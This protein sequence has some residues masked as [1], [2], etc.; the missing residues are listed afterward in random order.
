MKYDFDKNIPRDGTNSGKWEFM[1]V[2]TEHANKDTL[3]FW[4]ADMDFA[5]PPQVLESMH[6]RVEQQIFGYSL[7]DQAYLESVQ[8]WIKRRFEW[9]VKTQDIFLSGGVLPA[10]RALISAFTKEGEGVII[11]RPVYHPFT[12]IVLELNRELSNNALLNNDGYYSIDFDD[13]EQKAKEPN[14]KVMLFCSPHNPVGRVWTETE[15]MKVGQICLDN[16]VL[17]ISDEIHWDLV[18]KDVKHVPIATLFPDSDKIITCTAPSKTFNMAGLHMSNIIIQNPDYQ[19][20]WSKQVGL[21]L[22]NPIGIS[23][24]KAAYDHSEEWLEELKHYL[25]DNFAFV[26]TFIKKHL[27]QA[28]FTIPDGT[29]FVWLDLS[30]YGFSAE[31]LDELMIKKANVL[32]EGG[33]MF[34]PE[35]GQFQRINIACPRSLLKEGLQRIANALNS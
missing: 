29:Y 34:G 12:N 7:H 20:K 5:C 23:A 13:L 31:E 8:G 32:L 27:P 16:D 21:V 33:S 14:N 18:R 30:G 17:L 3:P 1:N 25:D 26:D 24:V 15:L 9:Q 19:D 11:Q 22:P 35:G 2:L 6:K 28:K 10:I 4:V